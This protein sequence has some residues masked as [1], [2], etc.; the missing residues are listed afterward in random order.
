MKT[1]LSGAALA[2]TLAM[3]GAAVAQPDAKGNAPLKPA[4]TVNDGGSK[5]GR[6]SF[7]EGQ[8]R[9]HIEKAGFS[10][11]TNLVKGEDGVWRGHA[12]RGGQPTD[13]AM[14]FKGN[15]STPAPGPDA[16]SARGPAP[17]VVPPMPADRAAPTETTTTSEA[18]SAPAPVHHVRRHRR[19]RHHNR[20][21]HP[22]ANGAACSGVDRNRNG[23]SDRED[24]AIQ[25]GA[26]P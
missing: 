19:H 17:A 14:D 10:G 7:T 2:L 12:L 15:V 26:R 9:R 21:A 23:I 4:H 6:N 5:A 24:R 22:S 18:R 3:A 13:V 25:Q 16:A 8:A 11:V 20:C 1:L